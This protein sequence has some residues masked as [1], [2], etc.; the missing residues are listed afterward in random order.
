M[1]DMLIAA[2]ADVPEN[3]NWTKAQLIKVVISSI[4]RQ[5]SP[6]RSKRG[7]YPQRFTLNR[8]SP[9]DYWKIKCAMYNF[10]EPTETCAGLAFRSAI[11]LVLDRL[12]E[13]GYIVFDQNRSEI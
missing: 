3:P 7:A 6:K 1:T 5:T 4:K 8:E 11:V 9:I 13:D 12:N 2:T 10:T